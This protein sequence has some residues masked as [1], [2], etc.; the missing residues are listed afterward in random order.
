M[1]EKKLLNF[2]FIVNFRGGTYCSQV[3]A[4]EVNRSTLEWIKQIEKVKDQIKY[5]GDKIIEELKKEAMNEDNNV[6]PLSGLKNIWFTLYST[7]QG[8]FFINIVQTDIP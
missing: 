4:T 8:S 3:Q 6:T 7:K 1:R 2:T 5:L